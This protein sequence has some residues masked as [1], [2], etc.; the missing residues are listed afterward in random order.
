MTETA[1]I[2]PPTTMPRIGEAAPAFEAV[3]TQ[4][5]ISFPGD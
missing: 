5:N 2:D 1:Q 3:T 4:G